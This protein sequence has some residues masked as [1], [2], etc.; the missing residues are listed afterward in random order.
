MCMYVVYWT[1]ACPKQF[2]SFKLDQKM[3]Q[4]SFPQNESWRI[5]RQQTRYL[6]IA[7]NGKPSEYPEIHFN[8]HSD[9]FWPFRSCSD[10]LLYMYLGRN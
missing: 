2:N 8:C 3:Q 6:Q 9:H 5:A 1:Y 4:I 10:V 7:M